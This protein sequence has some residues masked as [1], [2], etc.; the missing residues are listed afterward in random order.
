MGSSATGRYKRQLLSRMPT[1][2]RVNRWLRL[3]GVV[4]FALGS[5]SCATAFHA[6]ASTD[7]RRSALAR[8]IRDSVQRVMRGAL[9]DG[10]FP[11]AYVVVGDSRGVLAEGGVGHLDWSK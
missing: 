8:E 11:G 7:A 3:A 4:T 2:E 5:A 10:A 6:A 9:R 1:S